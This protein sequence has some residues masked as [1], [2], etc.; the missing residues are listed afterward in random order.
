MVRFRET[1]IS[2]VRM[3]SNTYTIVK[4][5]EIVISNVH[6]KSNT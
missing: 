6:M 2:D 4:F 5:R 1:V 3:I